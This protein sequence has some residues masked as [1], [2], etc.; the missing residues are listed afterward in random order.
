M[1][2]NFMEIII[3]CTLQ[4]LLIFKIFFNYQMAQKKVMFVTIETK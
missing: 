3:F 1:I 2:T 4:V